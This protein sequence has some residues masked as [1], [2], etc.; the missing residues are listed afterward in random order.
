MW[1]LKVKKGFVIIEI[2][3]AL[4]IFIMILGGALVVSKN[5]SKIKC[6]YSEREKYIGFLQGVKN[7]VMYNFTYKDLKELKKENKLY[8]NKD[9]MNWDFYENKD[10]K[11]LFTNV[12]PKKQPYIEMKIS[13]N[14]VFK[15]NLILN[16]KERNKEKT[17][18]CEF[19]K[20]RYKR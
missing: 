11:I 12:L 5:A 13:E 16:Y 17:V 9:E 15:I 3:C 10:T 20:G 1:N 6:E 4:S 14:Q 7:E 18:Q 8:I 19:Y 2:L